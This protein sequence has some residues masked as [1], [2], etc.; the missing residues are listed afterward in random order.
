MKAFRVVVACCAPTLFTARSVPSWAAALNPSLVFVLVLVYC[1]AML[2][3]GQFLPTSLRPHVFVSSRL[4]VFAS[5]HLRVFASSRSRDFRLRGCES[6]RLRAF[7]V[8]LC[9][10]VFEI[11]FRC[12]SASYHPRIFE[13]LFFA[14]SRLLFFGFVPLR[15]CIFGGSLFIHVHVY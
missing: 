14:Y 6:S 10:R 2:V 11:S 15:F 13:L 3:H 9:F 1:F 5:S 8:S 4:R 12:G 7:V